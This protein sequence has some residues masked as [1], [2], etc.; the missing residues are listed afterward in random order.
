MGWSH[1]HVPCEPDTLLIITKEFNTCS[2]SSFVG[3]NDHNNVNGYGRV[4]KLWLRPNKWVKL[5]EFSGSFDTVEPGHKTTLYKI[6][7]YALES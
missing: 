3:T 2:E 1:G 6:F 7:F 5:N 4:F